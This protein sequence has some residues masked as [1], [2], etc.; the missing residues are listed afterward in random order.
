[1]NRMESRAKVVSAALEVAQCHE[2]ETF[3]LEGPNTGAEHEYADD[4]L[5]EAIDEYVTIKELEKT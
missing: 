2:R 4:N 1:M 5:D 3:E